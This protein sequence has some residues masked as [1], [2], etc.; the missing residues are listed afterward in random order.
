MTFDAYVAP[1]SFTG[2]LLPEPEPQP[3]TSTAAATGA[4]TSAFRNSRRR[5]G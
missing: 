3:D 4:P 2:M 5:E 1:L